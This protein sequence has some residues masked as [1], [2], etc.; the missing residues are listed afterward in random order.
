VKSLSHDDVMFD[1]LIDF[2][3]A[4]VD[5]INPVVIID[6]YD[7]GVRLRRGKKVNNNTVLEPGWHWKIP[8]IDRIITQMV[9]T[10]TIDLAEQTV[11]TKD[12]KSVVVKA[13][14]KYEINDV[15]KV[16]LEVNSPID[17]VADMSKGIIREAIVE[18][19][20]SECHDSE[21]SNKILR[22]VRNE[23][24]NWGI[25]VNK[26]TLTDLAEMQSI[27]LLNT[28]PDNKEIF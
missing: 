8:F 27:R 11:T 26:V 24:D 13:V 14:I 3:L 9:K 10:T 19:N 17:A 15:E 5:E 18:R 2:I 20:W 28:R 1:R 23:A 22:R 16:L 12:G 21:L 6:H 4:F 7:R 25:K